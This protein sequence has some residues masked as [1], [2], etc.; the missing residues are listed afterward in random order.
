MSEN[1][2]KEIYETMSEILQRITRVET[3]IDGYNHLREKIDITYNMTLAN[4]EDIKEIK[5]NRQWLQ[6]TSIGAL[7]TSTITL[8]IGTIV[9]LLNSMKGR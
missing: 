1:K 3:K 9:T 4:T 6:R 2:Y 7:I 5:D 8:I